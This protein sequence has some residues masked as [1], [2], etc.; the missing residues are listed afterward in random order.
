MKKL[1]YSL[2]LITA[3][4]CQQYPYPQEVIVSL[5][6]AEDNKA[7]LIKV[8]DFYKGKDSLKYEAAC[9]LIGNMIYH[10]SEEQYTLDSLYFDYFSQIGTILEKDPD[11]VNNEILKRGLA[12]KYDAIPIPTIAKGK[13]DAQTL[14]A[15]YII[16][17]I[18]H[19]FTMWKE[20][21][22]LRDVTFEEF[23]E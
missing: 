14:S 5:L 7:E 11:A 10:Q 18:E 3:F 2:F 6:K 12:N 9:F 17:N 20:S 22:L 8:L 4:S 13:P 16:R 15:E 1:F 19:S 21:P 23:K